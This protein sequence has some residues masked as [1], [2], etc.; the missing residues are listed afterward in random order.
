MPHGR[1][2]LLLVLSDEQYSQVAVM[3]NS[4]TIP[5]VLVQRAR[6]IVAC[7]K[8]PGG[9]IVVGGR[10]VAPPLPQTRHWACTTSCGTG[11]PGLR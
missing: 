11:G 10:Q 5:H 7:A 8:S 3:A 4:S 2:L 9:S 1:Q 6:I